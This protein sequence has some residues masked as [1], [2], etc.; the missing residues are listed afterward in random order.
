[1]GSGGGRE[2]IGKITACLYAYRNDPQ[3]RKNLMKQ[4]VRIA[5]PTALS[6]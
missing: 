1:M 2:V 3:E 5:T 4:E 6:W